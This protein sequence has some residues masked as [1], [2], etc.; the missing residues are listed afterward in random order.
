MPAD[1]PATPWARWPRAKSRCQAGIGSQDG[2]DRWGDYST[3]SVDPVDLCTFWYTN[4]YQPA[5]DAFNWNT[6]HRLVQVPDPRGAW[7]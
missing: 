5:T 4:Q 1:W 7:W 3:L 6:Q 2:A